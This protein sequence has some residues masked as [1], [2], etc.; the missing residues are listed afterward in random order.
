MQEWSPYAF[1][2]APHLVDG[3]LT[4]R[5]G[6]FRLVPLPGGGT[7]LE[8]ST[9]YRL[10]IHPIPYW[11]LFADAIVHRIHL[12]VLDHVRT[13]AERSAGVTP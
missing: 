6:E 5:R 9:W 10:R 1:V 4:S 13:L 3:T 7:R 11:R 2:N 8:G 12:R